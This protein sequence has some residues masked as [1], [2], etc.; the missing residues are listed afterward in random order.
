MDGGTPVLATKKRIIFRIVQRK[1]DRHLLPGAV[2]LFVPLA[3]T[4]PNPADMYEVFMHVD[5]V[6]FYRQ[7]DVTFHGELCP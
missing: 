5:G 1:G 4:F 7:F 2:I 6:F 3:Q